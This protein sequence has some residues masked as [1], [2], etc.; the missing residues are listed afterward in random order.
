MAVLVFIKCFQKIK[1][2]N[3]GILEIIFM[4]AV[5]NCIKLK[6]I[7]KL[8]NSFFWFKKTEIVDLCR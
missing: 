1:D 6:I 8:R 4:V 2:P 7:Y 3:V 5:Q